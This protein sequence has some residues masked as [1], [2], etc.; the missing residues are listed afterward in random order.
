MRGSARLVDKILK[1]TAPAEIPVE[2]PTLFELVINGSTVKAFGLTI[3]DEV[4]VLKD[5][6]I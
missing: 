3:P 5:R 2:Q 6:I 1:G 4:D